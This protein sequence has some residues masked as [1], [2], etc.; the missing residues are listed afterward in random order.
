MLTAGPRV[1]RRR[2]IRDATDAE[3]DAP[4][5][6]VAW[7]ERREVTRQR[8]CPLG[9]TGRAEEVAEA[10][11]GLVQRAGP[12]WRKATGELPKAFGKVRVM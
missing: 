12:A 7:H 5:G 3:R 9:G 2:W 4:E 10:C 6:A 8:Q 1:V 11:D